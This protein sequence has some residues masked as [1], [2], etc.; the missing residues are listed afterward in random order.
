MTVPLPTLALAATPGRRADTLLL[1]LPG[2]YHT[3]QD[4]V[5]HG[6][7][8][9]VRHLAAAGRP[10]PDLLLVDAHMNHYLSQTVLERLRA[11]V[12][13]P[14]RAAGW[15]RVWA[16]GISLGGYGALQLALAEA[17]TPLAL[18]GVFVMAA[19]LGRRDLPAAIQRAGGLAAWDGQHPGAD[20]HDLALWRWLRGYAQPAAAP[21]PGQPP[22]PPL[23]IG[24]GEDD[25]F[26]MSNRLLGA[27]L[28]PG[29]C[30]RTHGGHDWPAW[31][32]LWAHFLA[33][34]PWAAN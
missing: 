16:V 10:A 26:V 31:Q 24:W 6:F 32:R 11:D 7:A 4:F 8:Q 23:Y 22:R 30:Y 18:D 25:R 34:A 20:V 33:A 27:V 14:A 29:R 28:P 1:L 19:F 15:R 5:R 13:V 3:P 17:G 2:A 12:L 9:S 21:T